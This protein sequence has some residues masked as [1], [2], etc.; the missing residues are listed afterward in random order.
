MNLSHSK[1]FPMILGLFTIGNKFINN[2]FGRG[3]L[4]LKTFK[5]ATHECIW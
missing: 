1:S 5:L 2:P 4:Q 3:V